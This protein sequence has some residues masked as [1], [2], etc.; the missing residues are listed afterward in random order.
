MP[1]YFTEFKLL[2]KIPLKIVGLKNY[3]LHNNYEYKTVQD[4]EES[5]VR[6]DLIKNGLNYQHFASEDVLMK[7]IGDPQEF[8]SKPLELITGYHAFAYFMAK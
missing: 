4:L 5:D 1:V 6:N 8:I 2:W 3:M 7:F